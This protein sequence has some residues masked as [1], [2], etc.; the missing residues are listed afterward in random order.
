MKIIFTL[1]FLTYTIII[2]GQAPDIAA[3]KKNITDTTGSY[4]YP[5]ISYQFRLD[6]GLL[7]S[8]GVQHLYYGKTFLKKTVN[9]F[10]E[11]YVKAM[12]FWQEKKMDSAALSAQKVLLKDPTNLRMLGLIIQVLVKHKPDSRNIYLYKFQ[13]KRV[14]DCIMSSGDGNT[15]DSPYYV[16][17]VPD[18]YVLLEVL[19][20]S[21]NNYIRS[22]QSYKDGI[23]E[24]YKKRK[25]RLYINVVY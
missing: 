23:M 14:I 21:H 12:D 15:K 3:I 22:S 1:F 25:E 7:D 2:F 19:G 16:A 9:V 11:D 24:V 18:E 10:D 5:K 17:S 6:P 8:I 20:K 4:Y 13:A